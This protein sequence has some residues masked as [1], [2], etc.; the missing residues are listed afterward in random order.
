[1]AKVIGLQP[2]WLDKTFTFRNKPVT[3]VGL[4]PTRTRYPVV[5]K[6]ERGDIAYYPVS[7]VLK[8]LVQNPVAAD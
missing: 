5:G 7:V 1:M 6:N 4:A 3:I 8:S 2:E